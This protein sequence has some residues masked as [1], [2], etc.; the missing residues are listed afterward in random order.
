MPI[1][2]DLRR[3]YYGAAW[4]A[5]IRPRILQREG[6]CCKSCGKPNGA[7]ILSATWSERDIA[8]GKGQPV[9]RMAWALDEMILKWRDQHGQAITRLDQ[10]PRVRWRRVKVVLTVA[11]LNHKP[12]DDRDENLAALCQ[13]CHLHHDQYQH[14]SSRQA[15]RDRGRPLLEERPW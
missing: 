1:P 4:R 13:W 9:Y 11:H 5:Q 15:R 8:F 6:C 7:H 2:K 10:V 14:R 3:R 12:G